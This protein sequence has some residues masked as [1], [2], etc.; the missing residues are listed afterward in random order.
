M[1][2]ASMRRP[3]KGLTGGLAVLNVLCVGGG[4]DRRPPARSCRVAL[5]LEVLTSLG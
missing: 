3:G 1:S 4:P 2:R 5:F